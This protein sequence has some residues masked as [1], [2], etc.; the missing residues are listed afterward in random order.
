VVGEKFVVDEHP[1][2]GIWNYDDDAFDCSSVCGFAH[3]GSQ[4][5]E[6]DNFTPRLA[7]MDGAFETIWAGHV[8]IYRDFEN[9]SKQVEGISVVER[10]GFDEM[11]W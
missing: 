2:E 6:L 4:S 3:V 8:G 10:N 5:M 1:A 7:L 11:K 9:T